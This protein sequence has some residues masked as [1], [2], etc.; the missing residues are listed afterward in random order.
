MAETLSGERFLLCVQEVNF[1][2]KV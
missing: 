2:K 1:C